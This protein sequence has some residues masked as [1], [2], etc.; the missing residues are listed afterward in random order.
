[1][2]KPTD[3]D[4]VLIT[5]ASSGIGEALSREY[6]KKNRRVVGIARREE[7]LA[8]LQEELGESFRYFICDTTDRQAVE[9]VVENLDTVPLTA[10]LNAGVGELDKRTEVDVDLHRRT[11]ETNYFGVL[12]WIAALYPHYR[13]AE[14]A[15]IAAV[16]SLAGY[17]GLPQSPAYAASK[18]AVRV[19]VEGFRLTLTGSDIRFINI[20]PGFVDTPMT[21]VNKDPMPFL[22]PAEKAARYIAK[23]IQAGAMHIE[24]PLPM[25]LAMRTA[26][27]FP[28]GLYTRTVAGPPRKKGREN[29]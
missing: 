1:M 15:A 11:F 14:G 24:F 23:K 7:K 27:L 8:A 17:R 20:C 12:H 2:A 26:C 18:A 16:S 19:M 4:A 9:T 29:K 6:V 5:G 21:K 28:A 22:W 13:D 25:Q 10:I 3:R